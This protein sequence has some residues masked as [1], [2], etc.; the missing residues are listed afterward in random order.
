MLSERVIQLEAEILIKGSKLQTI[1][2]GLLPKLQLQ[3][4]N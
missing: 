1:H 2:I 3:E 4:A